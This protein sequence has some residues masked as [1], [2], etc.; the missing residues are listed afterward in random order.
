[1][2]KLFQIREVFETS[3]IY[4]SYSKAPA[5]EYKG[6]APASPKKSVRNWLRRAHIIK[7]I[8]R[9]EANT[10]Y[11]KRIFLIFSPVRL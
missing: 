11:S 9:A 1:M 5:L 8:L 7:E 2:S 6:E 3:R 10:K 4:F